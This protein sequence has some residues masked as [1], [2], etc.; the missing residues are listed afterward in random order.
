MTPRRPA[1]SIVVPAYNE[2]RRLGPTLAALRA[3]VDGRGE[4]CEVIV[5][6]DGS[7]DQTAALVEAVIPEFPERAPLR[8]LR[9]RHN[10]GKGAAVRTGM[11]AAEGERVCFTDADL[12]TPLEE[13]DRVLEPLGRGFDVAVGSRVQPGGYDMR[14]SQPTYRRLLG[15]SYSQ[16]RS[17]LV[18]PGIADPQCPLKCFARPAARRLFSAQRSTGWVFD[19]EILYLARRMGMRI[20]VVPVVWEHRPGSQLRPTVGNATRV[21][22]DLARIRWWHRG[23]RP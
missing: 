5:V 13:I 23:A 7:Q 22:W 10:R 11:L 8:L 1:L 15:R 9:H 12:A 4:P 19:T 3:Y 20:A 6:D 2:A 14:T 17:W 18:L 21:A 16:L